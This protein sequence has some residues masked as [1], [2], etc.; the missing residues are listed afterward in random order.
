MARPSCLSS[1]IAIRPNI[2]T[3]R[4]F[5]KCVY[6]YIY[7]SSFLTLIVHL[8]GSRY[9]NTCEK[10]TFPQFRV[11][12]K[13]LAFLFLYDLNGCRPPELRMPRTG[14]MTMVTMAAM[15]KDGKAQLPLVKNCN[16]TKHTNIQI[17]LQMCLYIYFIH[18]YI[19]LVF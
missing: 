10:A 14:M 18:I 19:F 7:I 17:F 15:R 8:L 2:Q 12:V 13:N 16:K 1:K 4:Y 6:I 9:V 5:Y 3:S 11:R